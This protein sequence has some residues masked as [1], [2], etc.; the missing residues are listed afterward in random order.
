MN[1]RDTV[2]RML[3]RLEFELSLRCDSLVDTMRHN[4]LGRMFL[5]NAE[6]FEDLLE[7][8]SDI[9]EHRSFY[10]LSCPNVV[11]WLNE[12]EGIKKMQDN[13]RKLQEELESGKRPQV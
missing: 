4:G 6:S 10:A 8:F 13:I 3:E 2:K 5:S 11:T 1:R 12:L 9:A 7:Q